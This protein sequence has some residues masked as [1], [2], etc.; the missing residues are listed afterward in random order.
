MYYGTEIFSES[1][2]GSKDRRKA[3]VE[4][5]SRGSFQFKVGM[6]FPLMVE[7]VNCEPGLSKVKLSRLAHNIEIDASD[8]R[9]ELGSRICT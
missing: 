9:T 1:G 2:N 4:G 8:F 6:K 7:R 3:G 5:G